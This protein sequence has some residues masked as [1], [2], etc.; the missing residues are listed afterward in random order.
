MTFDEKT[1]NAIIDCFVS[2]YG[3]KHR[4]IIAEKINNCLIL[5]CGY[6]SSEE[7]K[8]IKN[9]INQKYLI[10]FTEKIKKIINLSYKEFIFF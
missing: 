2:V 6:K 9:R 7:R 8:V 10:I 1:L 3:E 5:L 4:K